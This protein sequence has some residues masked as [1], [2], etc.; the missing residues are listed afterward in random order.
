MEKL[1]KQEYKILK[2]F[3]SL[4]YEQQE[5][6]VKLLKYNTLDQEQ[7]KKVVEWHRKH[8]ITEEM[9]INTIEMGARA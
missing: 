3:Q 7:Q 4:S 1:T 9:I 5:N 2:T 8:G 6:L